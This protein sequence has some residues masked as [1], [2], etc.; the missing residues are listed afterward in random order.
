MWYA[1][2]AAR[3]G[4]TVYTIGIGAGANTDFLTTMAEGKDPR[5]GGTPVPMFSGASGK[6]FP[7]ARPSDL[8]GI[9]RQILTSLSVRIV[10]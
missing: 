10:G 3:Q 5:S 4:V 1:R 6:Y 2:E 7:A 9:F 8:D